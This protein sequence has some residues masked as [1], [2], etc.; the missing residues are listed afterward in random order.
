[1]TVP[2]GKRLP[3]AD[4]ISPCPGT[5]I[6]CRRR[7]R[8]LVQHAEIA[9]DLMAYDRRISP[10]SENIPCNIRCRQGN[11]IDVACC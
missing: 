6:P 10:Q 1:M 3:A 2:L 4:I 5:R 7:A 9:V 8:S 11:Q